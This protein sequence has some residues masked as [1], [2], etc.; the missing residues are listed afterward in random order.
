MKTEKHKPKRLRTIMCDNLKIIKEKIHDDGD[1][2]YK[3]IDNFEE[4]IVRFVRH[5]IFS[6]DELGLKV[7][8]KSFIGDFD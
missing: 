6:V 8:S 5:T 2:T 1:F 3:E 7:T 4:E